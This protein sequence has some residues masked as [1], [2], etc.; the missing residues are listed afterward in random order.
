MG[1]DLKNSV[2]CLWADAPESD[3]IRGWHC[4]FFNFTVAL[5]LGRATRAGGIGNA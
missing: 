5:L 4:Q 3:S 2:Y 1:L